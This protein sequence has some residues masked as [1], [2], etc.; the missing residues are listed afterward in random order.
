MSEE[1]GGIVEAPLEASEVI[2]VAPAESIADHAAQYDPKRQA[3]RDAAELAPVEAPVASTAALAKPVAQPPRHRAAKDRAT[4]ADAPRIQELNRKLKERDDELAR[5]RSQPVQSTTPQPPAQQAQPQPRAQQPER[6]WLAD[7]SD[8]EPQEKNFGGDPMKYLDA[9]YEWLA[10]GVNRYDRHEAAQQQQTLQRSQSWAQ[11]VEKAI[12]KY[13]DYAAVAF[14]PTTIPS[15]SPMD[16]FIDADDNGAEV[17]YYLQSNPAERDAVLRLPVIQQMKHLA[18]LSQ[19]YDTAS[20]PSAQA[21][22]TGSVARANLRIMPSR[23][24]NPVRTGAQSASGGPPPTDG[25]LSITDHEKQFG[26][27]LRRRR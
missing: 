6:R 21:G 19:R 1:I 8:P 5:L 20:A 14:G 13:Q 2:E 27:A 24:P 12:D 17:L 16:Q 15:G 4:A 3:E 9:R 22:N 18:L 7:K 23:P 26:S 11:R 10:R 25:S